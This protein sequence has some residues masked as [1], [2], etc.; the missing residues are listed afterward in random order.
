M[1]GL[2]SQ[3]TMWDSIH[4]ARQTAIRLTSYLYCFWN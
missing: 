2:A 1:R 4:F 3:H